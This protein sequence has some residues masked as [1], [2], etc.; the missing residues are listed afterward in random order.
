MV[1]A[2]LVLLDNK[3]HTIDAAVVEEPTQ[4]PCKFVAGLLADCL[5]TSGMW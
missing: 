4:T 3:F 2:G 5:M 1:L